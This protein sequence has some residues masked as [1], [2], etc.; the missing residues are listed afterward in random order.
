MLRGESAGRAGTERLSIKEWNAAHVV[1]AWGLILRVSAESFDRNHARVSAPVPRVLRL[2][3]HASRRRRRAARAGGLQGPGSSSTACSTSS[4]R[5]KPLHLSIVG[6]E[7]LVRFRE[8]DVLL[9]KLTG[10]GHPHAGRDERRAA[11]SRELGGHAAP[12]GVRLDR[13]VAARARCAPRA[14]DLRSHPEAHQGAAGHGPLHD[15]A[16]AD[17]ARVPHR[18]HRV[19][20]E[21]R[22]TCKRIWFSLYT[23]QKGEQSAGDGCGPRI[24]S[25][26]STRCSA[27]YRA[28][29]EARATCDRPVVQ[30]LP[31]RRRRRPDECIFA[32]TTACL[33][34]DLKRAITP[35]QYGGD[36]DCTQCGCLASVGLR[37]GRRATGSA[38]WC[39][40]GPSSMRP[41]DRRACACHSRGRRLTR[42]L[43]RPRHGRGDDHG[44]RRELM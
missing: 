29:A 35:C 3:R 27:L 38:A 2:R 40:C 25:A 16:P 4:R 41:S 43:E 13:R 33:S 31:A 21:A 15:H 20:G 22:R 26:W 10:D 32:K 9:P 1:K 7:P 30:R 5:H 39:R 28:R 18:V 44:E 12:A 19:L 14:G 34:S 17:A 37:R 11:D 6:G 36:P 8:L 24:A 23:P 42:R